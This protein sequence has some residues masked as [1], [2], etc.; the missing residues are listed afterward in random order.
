MLVGPKTES[1]AVGNLAFKCGQ[2]AILSIV[3]IASD[4]TIF[5]R[6]EFSGTQPF[7]KCT[8]PERES[9]ISF[10]CCFSRCSLVVVVV[11]SLVW[12]R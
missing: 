3:P 1:A 11:A 4:G 8:L 12:K 2:V 6:V 9:Q 5:P 7:E 10:P